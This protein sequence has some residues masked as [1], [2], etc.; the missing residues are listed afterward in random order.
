MRW[1][2]SGAWEKAIA[3]LGFLEPARPFTLECIGIAD[4]LS[5]NP[6]RMYGKTLV[7]LSARKW[8]ERLLKRKT[9]LQGLLARNAGAK[10]NLGFQTDFGG[11][12][13]LELPSSRWF[14]AEKVPVKPTE[15]KRA[16]IIF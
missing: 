4:Q 3:G 5:Q 11:L 6:V 9:D 15:R 1:E 2:P 12:E 13:I 10:K 7:V 14:F 16:R 8:L